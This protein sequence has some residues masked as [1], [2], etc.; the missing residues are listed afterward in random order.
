MLL[1]LLQFRAKL[2]LSCRLHCDLPQLEHHLRGSHLLTSL[3]HHLRRF[4]LIRS[5][6][7][8]WRG[9]I[10]I[11]RLLCKESGKNQGLLMASWLYKLS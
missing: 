3:R 6:D 2:V 4:R 7:A 9:H 5:V 8:I 1:A 10:A 11:M